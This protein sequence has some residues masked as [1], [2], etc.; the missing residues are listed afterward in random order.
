M[1]TLPI[2]I[3]KLLGKH[4]KRNGEIESAPP[5]NVNIIQ[6]WYKENYEGLPNGAVLIQSS[7]G[8]I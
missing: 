4:I 5:A 7:S 2:I 8:Q 3:C 1:Y 6:N